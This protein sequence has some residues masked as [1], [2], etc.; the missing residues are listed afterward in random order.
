MSGLVSFALLCVDLRKHPL[1]QHSLDA[2]N[3]GLPMARRIAADHR[4]VRLRCA[5][6]E[7]E[8]ST[9]ATPWCSYIRTCNSYRFCTGDIHKTAY[10]GQEVVFF[11]RIEG[12]F[13]G[14][15]T[16]TIAKGF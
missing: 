2:G 14:G 1:R 11:W 13:A 10:S 12:H 8:H 5:V 7:H 9:C 4:L 16:P 15:H 6:G 3:M